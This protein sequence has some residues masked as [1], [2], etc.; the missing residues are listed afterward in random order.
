M[1][2]GVVDRLRLR[3]AGMKCVA[4]QGDG[5]RD[6]VDA[7]VQEAQQQGATVSHTER[8]GAEK[9]VSLSYSVNEKQVFFP[10]WSPAG[11]VLHR[12]PFRGSV[13]SHGALRSGPLLSVCGQP[14]SW[15][16]AASHVLQ[17]QHR[18]RG[19]G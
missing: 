6:L 4:L 13:P 17:K 10:L 15:T 11:P 5:D 16:A 18:S 3:M 8:L 1:L 9:G 12:P 19:P 2:H 7:A 14:L